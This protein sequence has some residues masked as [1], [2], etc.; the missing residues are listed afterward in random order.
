MLNER[1]FTAVKG[2]HRRCRG[3]YAVVA[4]IMGQGILAFRDPHGIRPVVL[5]KR[6]ENGFT[7]YMVASESVALDVAGF[8]IV[9]N[10]LPG[11]AIYIEQD[12]PTCRV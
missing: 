5:G 3:G 10:V 1:V 8:E 11:E 2:V 12:G 7:E 6:K 9:R 4:M